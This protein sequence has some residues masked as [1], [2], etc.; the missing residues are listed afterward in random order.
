MRAFV[1][2]RYGPPDVLRL[3]TLPVPHPKANEVLIRVHATT[4]S[5][6]DW[7]L[8]SL[9]VPRGL[10]L[11]MRLMFGVFRPRKSIL[12]TELS[13]VVEAV[14]SAVTAW[15]P[16]DAVVGFPGG[17]LGA[18]AEFVTMPA[19]GKIVAKPANL[20]FDEA[21]ALPFGA[22]TAYDFLINKGQLQSAERVLINGASGATGTAFVQL[23]KHVG[24]HVTAVCSTGN[25]ELV[26]SLGADHVIDYTTEDF[27]T[28]P[29]RFDM[30]IDTVG[31][32]PWARSKQVLKPGGR[33]LLVAGQTSDMLFG[34]LKARLSGKRLIG[35][36]AAET[37]A[38]LQSVVDLAAQGHL[39]PVIGRRY[40]FEQMREAHSYV[41]NGHKRGSVV[42][43]V[44]DPPSA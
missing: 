11:P 3:A 4:V 31:T 33:M 39:Q 21:A 9:T 26:C 20:S 13:G 29:M 6:A 15:Q 12:G 1:Y 36:V 22:C 27:T 19:D 23:A 2:D 41:D 32:A 28:D 40:P 8:R 7:R 37:P 18:H 43:Q 35:G 38:L 17:D 25:V 42:V 16:G 5:A 24:A 14:G 34:A 30:V 10:A 44:A